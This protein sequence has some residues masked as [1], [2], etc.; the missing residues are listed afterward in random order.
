[1]SDKKTDYSFPV[2]F[3]DRCQVGDEMLRCQY[4]QHLDRS[5]VTAAV[6]EVEVK[7]CNDQRC[8]YWSKPNPP[9]DESSIETSKNEAENE[10]RDGS[11]SVGPS[12]AMGPLNIMAAII[13]FEST[14]EEL[15]CSQS[16]DVLLS[17]SSESMG[18]VDISRR[19]L[20]SKMSS[21]SSIEIQTFDDDDETEEEE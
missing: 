21:E 20:G 2:Y 9:T 14:Y 17:S 15:Q 1:M 13:P 12:D 4:L 16:F 6:T 10:K 3:G 5:A 19:S 7:S 11:T 18:T 8:S